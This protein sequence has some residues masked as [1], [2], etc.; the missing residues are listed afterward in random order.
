MKV[1]FIDINIIDNNIKV[2][3]VLSLNNIGIYTL[4]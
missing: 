1:L 4:T 2:F 3:N